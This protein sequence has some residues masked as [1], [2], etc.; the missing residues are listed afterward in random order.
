MKNSDYSTPA[1]L[2]AYEGTFAIPAL[3]ATGAAAVAV[4]LAAKAIRGDRSMSG[5]MPALEPCELCID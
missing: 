3:L 2:G 4:G 1:V 5:S